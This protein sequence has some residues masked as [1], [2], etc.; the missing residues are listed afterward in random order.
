[1][2]DA[3]FTWN[4]ARLPGCEGCALRLVLDGKNLF[5]TDNV[6]ALR[7]DSGR[8]APSMETLLDVADRPVTST[9]PIPRESERYAPL[10]DLDGNGVIA[11][12]E[13]DTARFAAA[14]DASDPSLLFGEPRQLRLGLEVVF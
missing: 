14:L 11:A 10:T 7:R 2:F 9:F 4:F 6:I 1:V 5:G 8:L 12:S 3:R 13:F